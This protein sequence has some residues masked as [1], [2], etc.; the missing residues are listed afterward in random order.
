MSEVKMKMMDCILAN[1]KVV[2]LYKLKEGK[3]EQSFG[4]NVAKMVKLP[5]GI[6][7]IAE[8]YTKEM[9]E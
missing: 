5:Q 1:D 4:L 6:I 3:A 7:N 8:R 2:F 9:E